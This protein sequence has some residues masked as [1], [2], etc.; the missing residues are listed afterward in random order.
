MKKHYKAILLSLLVASSSLMAQDKPFANPSQITSNQ[1]DVYQPKDFSYLLGMPGF[2]DNALN[3]H[4]TLYKGYVKNTNLLLQTL[5]DMGAKGENKTPAF[6]ELRRRFGWEFDGMRLHELYF[7]NLGGKDSL[8]ED[9]KLYKKIVE[10]F[11]SFDA[12]KTDFTASGAIR[13]IGWVVLYQ[14]PINGKLINTWVNEH[15]LGNL[16]GGQPILIMDVFEHAYIPDYQLERGKY[17]E[18]FFNNINW[19]AVESRLNEPKK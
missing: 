4:F 19:N 5:K 9:S 18:A 1:V 2:S 10:D 14:D 12:W 3:L 13:G 6:G 7:G 8:K 16:V 11:G 15:D 17:I